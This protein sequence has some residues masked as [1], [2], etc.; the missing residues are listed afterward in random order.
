VVEKNKKIVAILQARMG[1]SR[2]PGKVLENVAGL[3][4]IALIINRTRRSHY[5]D[6]LVVATTQLSEDDLIKICSNEFGVP[7]YRG[8]E[9]DC[10]DRYYQAAK[11][12]EARIIVRLT[13]DNPFVDFRFVDWVIE[14][15]LSANPPFDYI[16]TTISK[17]FPL[18]L[19]VEVFSFDVLEIA[20]KEESNMRRRE[21]VTPFITR[22][23]GLFR[24]CNL[25]S[26]NDYSHIRLTVDT[27]EDLIFIRRIYDYF[28]HDRFSWRDVLNVLEQHPEWLEINHQVK[29]KVI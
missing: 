19:S 3:P 14:K 10:L 16:D 23:P 18:G 25:K 6:Q 28:G 7:C 8:A 27:Q 11:Q 15:Y 2:L 12:Y 1:S 13:G 21:H 17:T 9:G 5:I 29:Q 24:I 26:H 4:M 22:H 20:W